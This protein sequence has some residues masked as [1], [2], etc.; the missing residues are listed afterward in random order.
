V[1]GEP[2]VDAAD[3]PQGRFP[4][5]TGPALGARLSGR[6]PTSARVG[7]AAVDRL[8]RRPCGQDS[9]PAGGRQFACASD[10]RC[11]R[12]A[13]EARLAGTGRGL[14]PAPCAVPLLAVRRCPG[15]VDDAR[16]CYTEVV[17]LAGVG[18]LPALMRCRRTGRFGRWWAGGAVG[19]SYNAS[20]RRQCD[21]FNILL[22]K[23]FFFQARILLGKLQVLLRG[24]GGLSQPLE[25]KTCEAHINPHPPVFRAGGW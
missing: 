14:R 16:R 13:I 8:H 5:I 22:Q 23:G 10:L 7:G 2:A 21:I 19:I 3:R 20:V 4:C 12:S 25:A 15:T 9:E 11:A 17:H 1:S 24:G 18:W 6:W